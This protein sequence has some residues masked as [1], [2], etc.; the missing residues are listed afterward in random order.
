MFI[1]VGSCPNCATEHKT[2]VCPHKDRISVKYYP[3]F[4]LCKPESS[5]SIIPKNRIS[6][7]PLNHEDTTFRLFV[8]NG[9]LDFMVTYWTW[10][11]YKTFSF[12]YFALGK[13]YIRKFSGR[14]IFWLILH[15][16]IW[17][18]S[19]QFLKLANLSSNLKKMVD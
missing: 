16:L 15:N 8:Q 5:R 2:S 12:L 11:C 19:H 9:K 17:Y 14:Q 6:D 3:K 13:L 18:F 1:K 4:Y 7:K 10:K